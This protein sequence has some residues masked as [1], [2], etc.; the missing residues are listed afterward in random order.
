MRKVITKLKSWMTGIMVSVVLLISTFT[1]AQV[2]TQVTVPCFPSAVVQKSLQD[3]KYIQLMEVLGNNTWSRSRVD[4][5]CGL[6]GFT[7]EFIT[8]YLYSISTANLEYKPVLEV[9]DAQLIPQPPF[10]PA[11]FAVE[12]TLCRKAPQQGSAQGAYP[13][14]CRKNYPKVVE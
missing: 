9:F 3:D 10:Y 2:P 7:T 12:I 1:Y 11:G 13:V 4:C 5:S 6:R 8:V 14:K